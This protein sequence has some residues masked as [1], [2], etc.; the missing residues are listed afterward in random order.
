MIRLSRMKAIR[1][2]CHVTQ[3]EIGLAL[4]VNTAR[5][6]RLENGY[7]PA[8]PATELLKRRVAEFLGYSVEHL[9]PE[10]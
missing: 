9:F 10:E 8:S 7:L 4:G 2:S 5:I 6:S 1:L 3:D